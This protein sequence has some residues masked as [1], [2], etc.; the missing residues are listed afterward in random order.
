MRLDRWLFGALALTVF[1][2][3]AGAQGLKIKE[4]KPGLLARAKIAPEMAL[5]T[6]QAAVPK[7]KLASS[8]IEEEDGALVFVFNF[9]TAGARGEDEVLVDAMT[10]KLVKTEHESP[11][12]EAK[13]KK[14]KKKPAPA[15]PEP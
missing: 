14:L 5:A 15:S 4:D 12:S 1:A 9:R 7:A 11:E 3:P 8:E 10:G 13:A 6:A 2:L